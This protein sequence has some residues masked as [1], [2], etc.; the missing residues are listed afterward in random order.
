MFH[1][2]PCP[3]NEPIVRYDAPHLV[4]FPFVDKIAGD[5]EFFHVSKS[6]IYP[7]LQIFDSKPIFNISDQKENSK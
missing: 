1:L 4:V 3:Q 6:F 7:F 5:T 2:I